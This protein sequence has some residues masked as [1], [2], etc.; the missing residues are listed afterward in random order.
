MRSAVKTSSSTSA[1]KKLVVH[2]IFVSGKVQGVFYRKY[3]HKAAVERELTGW[4]RNL[5]DGRVEI[6][7]EGS[8]SAVQSL[9]K[10]C[11]TGSPKSKVT[12]VEIIEEETPKKKTMTVVQQQQDGSGQ[13][14]TKQVVEV[15]ATRR[16]QS[17][18]IRRW[19]KEKPFL[20]F[21]GAALRYKF[22][23]HWAYWRG[24]MYCCFQRWRI[25]PFAPFHKNCFCLSIYLPSQL[26][27][28]LLLLLLLSRFFFFFSLLL[29]LN[30]HIVY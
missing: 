21:F 9:E 28:L 6:M 24:L 2:H 26:Y 27:L 16:Y 30:L 29:F 13:Q 1:A 14:E 7:A 12:G 18:E 5:P 8:A 4:V 25:C 11:H 22:N 3:T 15:P 23:C 19:E 10:W 20:F 17:F